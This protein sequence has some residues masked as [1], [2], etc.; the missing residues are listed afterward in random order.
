M[1]VCVGGEYVS[2]TAKS[3]PETMVQSHHLDGEDKA[4][5]EGLARVSVVYT[6]PGSSRMQSLGKRFAKGSS[7][8]ESFIPGFVFI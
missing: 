7:V 1:C 8:L 3:Y 2:N 6:V 4:K 5:R